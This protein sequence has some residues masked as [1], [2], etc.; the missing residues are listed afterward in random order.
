MKN[1]HTIVLLLVGAAALGAARADSTTSVEEA[2][3]AG[4]LEGVYALNP[5]LSAFAIET[6]VEDGV[7]TLSGTVETDVERD[8]ATEIA[9]GIE[10][11]TQVNSDLLVSAEDARDDT[12]K[13][14]R[15]QAFA[16]WVD[17]AT[18]TAAVKSKL[19]GNGNV[20][21]R[22]IN[23]DTD[24]DVVTLSG[25]VVSDEVRELAEQIARNT[26]DVREVRNELTVARN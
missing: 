16:S 5:H 4:K 3:I 6:H 12:E 19:I 26:Q 23:V 25:R 15:R 2:W 22:D 10:G 13:G 20:P 18:T 24:A 1:I 7:V 17:N 11:V 14:K 9:K 8:L 21:A